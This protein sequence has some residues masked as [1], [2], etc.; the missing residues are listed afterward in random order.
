MSNV[1]VQQDQTLSRAERMAIFPLRLSDF[2]YYMFVDDRPSHPMVFVMVATIAGR[3]DQ[4]AFQKSLDQAIDDHPLFDCLIQKVPDRGWCWVAQ[5]SAAASLQWNEVIADPCHEPV[6]VRSIDLSLSTGLQVQ[7][8]AGPLAA[9]VV[10]HIHHACCDG[11]AALQFIGEVFA[12]YGQA[13]AEPG[14][15]VPQFERAKINALLGRERFEKSDRSCSGRRRSLV[16]SIAKASRLILR[17]PVP[18]TAGDSQANSSPR[19][20]SSGDPAEIASAIHSV[21]LPKVV[22]RGLLASA[23]SQAVT[24][25]DLCIRELMLQMY[26]WNQHQ[27]VMNSRSMNSR[28]WLRIAIPLSMRSPDHASMPAANIVSYGF[29]TRRASECAVPEKLLQSIHEQ[30]GD[31]LFMREGIVFLKCVRFLR[32]IPGALKALLG[33]KSCFCTGVLANVGDLRRRFDGRFPL[34]DGCWKAGNVVVKDIGGVAPVRPN[35]GVAITVGDYG[36]RTT[37]HL[38]TDPLVFS[39]QQSQLFLDQ[40]V[41]RLT[42]LSESQS[43][44]LS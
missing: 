13:T 41:I 21:A 18:L 9:R 34:Q 17:K 10:F 4:V 29:V 39:P 40:F 32:A 28:S 11:I 3:L 43:N 8:D 16:R 22:C 15:K 20:L 25:N 37:L 36:G 44:C 12:R 5:N 23:R 7:V 27:S 38:R 30:T 19:D 33:F 14:Q 2:E 24:V 42:R 1:A 6:P 31:I 26:E 35:T